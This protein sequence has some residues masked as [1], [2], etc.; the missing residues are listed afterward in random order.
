MEKSPRRKDK[1]GLRGK[2]GGN[3]VFQ[4]RLQGRWL[5][6]VWVVESNGRFVVDRLEIRR[7]GRLKAHGLPTQ[8]L[9]DI[10]LP[11]FIAEAREWEKWANKYGDSLFLPDAK[12]RLANPERRGKPDS[13]YAQVACDYLDAIKVQSAKGQ[14]L[15][16]VA[17]LAETYQDRGVLPTDMPKE[18]ARRRVRDW[19]HR[20]RSPLGFLEG[21]PLGT[22]MAAGKATD[23]LNRWRRSQPVKGKAGK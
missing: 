7:A 17:F 9:R 4:Q 8:V 14:R 1:I 19:V 13:F 12:E 11:A 21:E 16:P 10:K 3:L 22:G 23:K 5:V 15:R 6:D 2:A 20:S 18:Q